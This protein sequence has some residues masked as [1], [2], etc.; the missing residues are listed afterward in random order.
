M[1][2]QIHSPDSMRR[3]VSGGSIATGPGGGVAGGQTTAGER[4][5]GFI[6]CRGCKQP[7]PAADAYQL[8]VRGKLFAFHP[9][10]FCPDCAARYDRGEL[11]PTAP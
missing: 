8:R 7:F 10:Q 5:V 4:P 1:P 9:G 6:E 3:V 11:D 2:K